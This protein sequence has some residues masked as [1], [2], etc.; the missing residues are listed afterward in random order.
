MLEDKY[1]SNEEIEMVDKALAEGFD[2]H[3][4]SFEELKADITKH[5]EIAEQEI[6][7]GKVTSMEDVIAEMEAKYR[8]N[9]II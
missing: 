2:K 7:E 8:I 3:Y 6:T 4:E 1:L 9:E 5:V